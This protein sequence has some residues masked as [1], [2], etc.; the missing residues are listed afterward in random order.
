MEAYFESDFVLP[1]SFVLQN[2]L[3]M[4]YAFDD[5]TD[6]RDGVSTLAGL[7]YVTNLISLAHIPCGVD[8]I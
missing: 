8:R 2:T 4:L 6:P 5:G 1:L 3:L 7:R